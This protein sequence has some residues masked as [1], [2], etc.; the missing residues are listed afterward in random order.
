M[1]KDGLRALTG[2]AAGTWR[3]TYLAYLLPLSAGCPAVREVSECNE[4]RENEDDGDQKKWLA[5]LTT[6]TGCYLYWNS[7]H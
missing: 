1:S 5:A 4:G 3:L 2:R 6:R 7:T